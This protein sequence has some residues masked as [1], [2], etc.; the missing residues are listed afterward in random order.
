L[1]P[2]NRFPQF[3]PDGRHFI[4]FVQ[5]P[6][7]QGEYASLLD[8]TSYKQLADSDAAA[9]VSPS[10]FLL[11]AR[12]TTLFTQTVDFKRLEL[13]GNPFLV[14]EQVT[15]DPATFAPGFSATAGIVA[16]RTAQPVAGN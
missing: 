2:Y 8:G 16:Y 1:S 6:R 12:Q 7:A 10:G 9:V 14:A 13:S 15:F 5:D 3:L 4:Y 11:F